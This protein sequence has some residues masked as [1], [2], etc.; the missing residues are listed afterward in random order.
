MVVFSPLRVV[1]AIHR[2]RALFSAVAQEIPRLVFLL[3]C[4]ATCA[5]S[6]TASF[7]KRGALG[8]LRSDTLPLHPCRLMRSCRSDFC[9]RSLIRSNVRS[10][11][12]PI[13]DPPP[14]PPPARVFAGR[15]SP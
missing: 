8:C 5:T 1:A 6:D 7:S 12:L 4:P 11:T 9:E 14:S 15:G 2:L 13:C 10:E 3:R